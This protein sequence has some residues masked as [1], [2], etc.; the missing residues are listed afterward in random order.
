MTDAD[1]TPG[2]LLRMQNEKIVSATQQEDAIFASLPESARIFYKER[3]SQT[4]SELVH[5]L[6]C[7]ESLWR[8]IN[9][10]RLYPCCCAQYLNSN[11]VVGAIVNGEHRLYTGPGFHWVV[12]VTDRMLEKQEI[13]EDID[14]GPIK[15]IFVRPGTLKFASLRNT[16][17]PILL[18]PGI[19]FMQT[20]THHTPHTTHTHTHTKLISMQRLNFSYPFPITKCQKRN[21]LLQ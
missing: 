4:F 15:V 5:K 16:G 12:G 8:N 20:H 14:F 17:K 3:S 7:C 2:A 6:T 9:L 1:T 21:A 10:L 19:T 18:G 13:G 11:Q